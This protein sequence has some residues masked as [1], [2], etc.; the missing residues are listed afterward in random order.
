[1]N[2]FGNTLLCFKTDAADWFIVYIYINCSINL[3]WIDRC[4][5]HFRNICLYSYWIIFTDK[6]FYWTVRYKL[7]ETIFSFGYRNVKRIFIIKIFISAVLLSKGYKITGITPFVIL[8][9]WP[10][11]CKQGNTQCPVFVFVCTYI[12]VSGFVSETCFSRDNSF[13]RI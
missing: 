1:M 11:T 5:K 12:A 8:I 3:C 6:K 4:R 10:A 13:I 7:T 2:F 9:W